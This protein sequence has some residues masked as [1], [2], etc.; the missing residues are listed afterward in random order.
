[1]DLNNGCWWEYKP[2]KIVGGCPAFG[3]L[4]VPNQGWGHQQAWSQAALPKAQGSS[5]QTG[6]KGKP[7]AKES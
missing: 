4:T 2:A 1:M 5:A 7:E 6:G 3:A